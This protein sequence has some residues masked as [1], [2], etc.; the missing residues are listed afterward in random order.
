MTS[1]FCLIFAQKF[2]SDVAALLKTQSIGYVV[3]NAGI[4]KY[5]NVSSNN[6]TIG[7][8]LTLPESD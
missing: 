5:P 1:A 7:L 4:L 6:S 2:A 8:D 3:L